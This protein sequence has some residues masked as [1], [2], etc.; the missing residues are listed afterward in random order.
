M[1]LS[2][3]GPWM[4]GTTQAAVPSAAFAEEAH[5]ALAAA[6]AEVPA[7]VPAASPQPCCDAGCA[8]LGLPCG[9]FGHCNGDCRLLRLLV[10][11]PALMPHALRMSANE[12]LFVSAGIGIRVRI[13]TPLLRPPISA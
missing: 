6:A 11:I 3:L 5:C 12:A 2:F 4:P 8:A 7:E 9:E 1:L 13:L 10:A